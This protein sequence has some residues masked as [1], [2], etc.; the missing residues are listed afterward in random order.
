LG[1]TVGKKATYKI[2]WFFFIPTIPST[3][4]SKNLGVNLTKEVKDLYGE[5]Y[6]TLKKLKKMSD[7][8]KTSHELVS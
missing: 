2:Q 8:G 6:K 3:I 4:T 1:N 5:N 7:D